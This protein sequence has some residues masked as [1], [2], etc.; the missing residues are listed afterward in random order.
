L[1]VDA[2]LT[3]ASVVAGRLRADILSGALPPGGKLRL[4]MLRERY[5]VGASPLRE[6][7]AS[8]TAEGL[9]LRLDQ[10]GFRVAGADEAA[11]RDLVETRCL[12]ETSALRAAIA[13]GDAAWEERVLVAHHRLAR[14]SRSLQTDTFVPNPEWDA[15]HRTF[16]LTLIEACG[17]PSLLA[18]CAELHDRATRFRNLANRV[19]WPQRDVPG[20]HASLCDA[21]IARRANEA[22]L[23]L[24]EHYRRTGGF[25][26]TALVP[27]GEV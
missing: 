10:R 11:L 4:E 14:A 17:A 16:H 24:E 19:A 22:V 6:A 21:A 18:F 2:N 26:G 15:L 1:A 27:S 20:E 23:L 12:V 3:L 5:G 7:L 13:R 25:V 9:V 8:L